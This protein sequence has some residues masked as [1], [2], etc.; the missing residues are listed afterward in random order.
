MGPIEELSS[1]MRS[2]QRWGEKRG[3]SDPSVVGH[4]WLDTGDRQGLPRVWGL[5]MGTLLIF[6]KAWKCKSS[7]T[8]SLDVES[9]FFVAIRLNH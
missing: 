8:N 4:W 7:L 6:W 3:R 5:R 2:P 9:L 1:M